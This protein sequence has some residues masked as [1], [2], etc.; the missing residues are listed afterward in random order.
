MDEQRLLRYLERIAESLERLEVKFCGER[1]APTPPAVVDMKDAVTA[2]RLR[3][4]GR[5]LPDG[6]DDRGL[7]RGGTP[8]EEFF[9][10]REP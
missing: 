9:G 8:P 10:R 7:T 4:G 3:R 2:V 1:P 6:P 5:R